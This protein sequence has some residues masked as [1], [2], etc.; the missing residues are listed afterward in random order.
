MGAIGCLGRMADRFC[1][2]FVGFGRGKLARKDLGDRSCPLFRGGL[3]E[4][5]EPRI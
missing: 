5:I 4:W 3:V 2:L 1:L